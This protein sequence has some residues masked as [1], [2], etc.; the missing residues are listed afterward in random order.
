MI[1][2]SVYIKA[3]AENPTAH[4]LA[5][6][7]LG[8]INNTK[9]PATKEGQNKVM[10]YFGSLFAKANEQAIKVALGRTNPFWIR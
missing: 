6:A 7:S 4:M 2:Q 5:I 1:L 8:L 3:F 9:L 10:E